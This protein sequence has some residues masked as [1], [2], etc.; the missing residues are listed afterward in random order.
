MFISSGE[1]DLAE[2]IVHLV[3][4]RLPDAPQGTR[5]ISLFVVPKITV[6]PDGELGEF[7]S[8]S[9]GSVEHKMGLKGSATCVINFD[10]A[11]GYLVGPANKG[12][13]CMFTFMNSSRLGVAIQGQGQAEGAYQMSLA[14]ASERTQGSD[15]ELQAFIHLFTLFPRHLRGL[16]KCLI[17]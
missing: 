1:H 4:A 3:L 17:M 2:N 8:V 13:A 10:S 11:E 9:C 7:N 6:K 16:L 14:Y 5:G 15:Y 12:L